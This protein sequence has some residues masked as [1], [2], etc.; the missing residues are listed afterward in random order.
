MSTIKGRHSI[1]FGFEFTKMYA[2]D[3][4]PIAPEG[5]FAFDGEATSSSQWAGDG[6]SFADFLLGVGNQDEW[7]NGYTR[8]LFTAEANPYYGTYVQD[9]WRVTPKLT[10]NLG[11]R[12]DIFGGRT[13]RHN[14]LEWFNPTIPYTVNSVNL[15]GGEQFVKNGGS[16]FNT[17]LGDFGPRFGLAYQATQNFVVRGGFGIYYGPSPHMVTNPSIN[18]DGF[19]P[20][21]YWNAAADNLPGGNMGPVNGLSNPF[22]N[23]IF[24]GTGSSLGPATN[25]GSVLTTVLRTSPDPAAY[26]FNFGFDYQLPKGYVV[27]AAWVGSR[28]LHLNQSN[29]LDLNTLPLS[30]IQQYNTSLDNLVHNT[31]VNAITD[32]TAAEFGATQ[33]TQCQA[34][35][36]YPQFHGTG[37]APCPGGVP[38]SNMAVGDS[39][40]HSLQLKLEKRMT[41]YFTTLT[42]FTWGKT[43]DDV[44]GH[45]DFIGNHP[46]TTYQDWRD[47]KYERSLSSQDVNRWFSYQMSYDLPLGRDRAL[48]LTNPVANG[49]LGKWTLN[50]VLSLGGGIPLFVTAGNLTNHYF[51]QRLD[52]VCDPAQGAPHTSTEWFLPNCFARPPSL[53]VP[54]T[55]PRTLNDVRS[56]GTRDLDASLQ[57]RV[58]LGED[59]SL[60]LMFAAYNL[61]NTVQLGIPYTT[62]YIPAAGQTA[63]DAN[64]TFGNITHAASTPRQFQFS[65]RFIF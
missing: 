53:F 3:G 65:A 9:E 2:N 39:I 49:I 22:P 58:K 41:K 64:P 34:L 29:A 44:G 21:T 43:L 47:R 36:T 33:I 56:P 51:A 31:Y 50:T 62:F 7:Q 24:Y 8:D 40:Y 38:I 63:Q 15:V 1:K 48:N 54:G 28:G 10:L 61:T 59:K 25:L 42:S 4:Q 16:P 17:N 14:Q 46:G 19:Y 11:L 13:A 23:G 52:L 37:A 20:T 5:W 57:K 12:W 60:E 18:S 27:S 30:V 6:N 35:S 32:P 55:M 45:L 26:D